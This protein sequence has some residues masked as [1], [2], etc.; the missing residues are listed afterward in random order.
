MPSSPKTQGHLC[1][2][3]FF[4][5]ISDHAFEE[6]KCFCEHTSLTTYWNHHATILFTLSLMKRGSTEGAHRVD[7]TRF[8][9]PIITCNAMFIFTSRTLEKRGFSLVTYTTLFNRR[10]VIGV[11]KSLMTCGLYMAIDTPRLALTTALAIASRFMPVVII[12]Q[13]YYPIIH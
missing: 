7:I 1:F 8:S 3:L 12:F 6:F 9:N 11:C 5:S 4:L 10:F 2:F 13:G